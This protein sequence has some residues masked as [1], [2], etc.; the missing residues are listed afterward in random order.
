MHFAMGYDLLDKRVRKR[1]SVNLDNVVYVR[2]KEGNFT[3]L[4]IVLVVADLIHYFLAVHFGTKVGLSAMLI[5]IFFGAYYIYSKRGG[6]GLSIDRFIYISYSNLF[7]REL[8]VEEIKLEKIHALDIKKHLLS[9][10]IKI[11]YTN[12]LGKLKE[13]NASYPKFLIDKNNKRF[14]KNGEGIYKQLSSLQ[15]VLDKGDF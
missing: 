11:R 1:A 13:V 14:Q 10:S 7:F 3:A 2:R 15:K 8:K 12:E 6:F 4:L 9:T 5:I